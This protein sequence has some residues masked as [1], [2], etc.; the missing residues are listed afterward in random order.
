MQKIFQYVS[1]AFAIGVLVTFSNCGS[2]D[3]S[4]SEVMTKKLIA[5]PWKLSIATV[6]GTDKTATYSGLTIT[7]TNTGYTATNGLPI[8][9]ASGTWQFTG[10]KATSITRND[11]LELAITEATDATLK[12]TFTWNKTTFETGRAGSVSGLHV[13]TFTK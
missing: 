12:L 13:F 2:N 3:P 5:H 9:P 7:F 11:G 10:D 4:A 8:W 1:F 6:D